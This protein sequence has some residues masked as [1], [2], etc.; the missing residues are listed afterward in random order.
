MSPA[1]ACRLA[2][3]DGSGRG[4]APAILLVLTACGICLLA[5]KA[6]LIYL[7]FTRRSSAPYAFIVI[8]WLGAFYFAALLLVPIATHLGSPMENPILI[9]EL[10]GAVIG[11]VFYTAYLLLSKRVKATFVVR[12]GN[13]GSGPVMT[14]AS[15]TAP[16]GAP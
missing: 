15:L 7:F 6:L 9:G 2:R 4:V 5:A 1:W 10:I 14:G 8:H 13:R 12:L 11:P 3:D 16:A